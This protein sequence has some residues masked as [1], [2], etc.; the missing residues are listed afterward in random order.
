MTGKGHMH[1]RVPTTLLQSLFEQASVRSRMQVSSC[2]TCHERFPGMSVRMSESGTECL[3]CGRDKHS[4]KSYSCE[5]VP[6]ELV[7]SVLVSVV[8][9]TLTSHL[10]VTGTDPDRGDAYLSS[11]AYHVSVDCPGDSMGTVGMLS[12]SPRMW[13]SLLRV[14]PAFPLNWMSL[15]SGRRGPTRAIRTSVSDVHQ[16]HGDFHVRRAVVHRAL[17][18][19]VTHYHS[20]GVTIDTTAK[21]LPQDGNI[22]QLVLRTVLP[23]VRPQFLLPVTQLQQ[24]MTQVMKTCHSH[25]SQLV[26]HR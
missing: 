16:S 6:V 24:R 17:Q 8:S 4:P 15:W 19:L 23:L 11:D 2:I 1:P 22:S 5:T 18:W 12:T 3:Q 7:V 20:V 10:I 26:H 21:Q 25:L 9:F 13:P 14:C